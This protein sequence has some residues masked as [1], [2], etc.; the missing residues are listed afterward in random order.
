MNFQN[1]DD[2]KKEILIIIESIGENSIYYDDFKWFSNINYTTTTEYY[3]ELR[4]FL[5]SILDLEEFIEFKAEM[6]QICDA[7]H[8]MFQS[9]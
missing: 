5:Q 9:K 2:I 7:I 4:N 1:A 3:G 8:Q 6:F